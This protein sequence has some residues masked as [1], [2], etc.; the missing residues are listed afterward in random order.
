[1]RII[2]SLL[3]SLLSL[4]AADYKAGVGRI[5]ITPDKPIYLS[6]YANRD[7]ASE[8]VLHDLWAKALAFEDRKGA[9]VVI[10]TTDLIGL[11]RSLSD[12]VAARI[13]KQYGI[14]RPHLLLNSSHTHTGPLIRRNLEMLF[15]LG[16]E[17]QQVVNE[18]AEKLTD[19][20]VN[21]VGAALKDLEPVDLSLGNGRATFAINRRENTA[22][23]VKIGE[24]PKGPTDPDVPVLKV[25]S[26]DGKLLA[27]LFGYACHNTTLTGQFYRVSGDYAGFAQADFE[28]AHPGAT[29]MFMMLCGAD[30]NPYP[31]SKLELAEQ[32]GESL[33]K[34]VDRVLNEKL[35]RV[36][37]PIHAT[38]RIVELG[39]APESRET[40]EA[41]LKESNVWRVR[42]AKAMLRMYDNPSFMRRYP[43]PVQAF[44]FG[45]DLTVVALGGEV[46]V[47]Y[48]LRIK[49]EFGSKGIIVAGYSNDVMSYIPSLRV[50]KEGG[51]EANDS[52]IYYGL[53][54]P[55]DDQVEDQV[56]TTVQQVLK[57]VG[58]KP[59]RP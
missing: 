52:M 25:T 27:V 8:G 53:P 43:Y 15:E 22:S 55:Y 16:P 17:D 40:Y 29:A 48:V 24:N 23:G 44:Q 32:H 57:R 34:E 33:A 26:Q 56:I 7:H 11:P 4:S 21:V 19:N 46:V 45:K 14:E 47:D 38:F 41:R 42:H 49:R 9:R 20:L 1:M 13:E 39:F 54:G 30:Q 12:I 51:Y 50:L 37:G 36:H 59:Q 18:Y 2:P 3:L 10:V 35:A 6:G 31:R 28:K 5:I 58:R